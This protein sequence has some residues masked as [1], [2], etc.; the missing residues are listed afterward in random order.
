MRVALALLLALMVAVPAEARSGAAAPHHGAKAQGGDAK[1]RAAAKRTAAA[2]R[3]A[4]AKRKAAAKRRA[5]AKRAGTASGTAPSGTGAAPAA[6]A[7]PA[8]PATATTA[9]GASGATGSTAPTPA[10]DPAPAVTPSHATTVTASDRDDGSFAFTLSSATVY[11]GA[12]RFGLVNR[13]ASPHDLNARAADGTVTPLAAV[14]PGPGTFAD[15]SVSLPA[16]TYTLFCSLPGHE[17]AGMR[18][19]LRVV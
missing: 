16:G 6:T 13:D 15:A 10:A 12:I 7:A 14:D 8:A 5:A 2:K 19:T 1:R 18:A 3:R 11:A 4:A 17:A 9:P